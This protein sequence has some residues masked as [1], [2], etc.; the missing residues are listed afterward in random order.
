MMK[1]RLEFKREDM[2]IG[3]FWRRADGTRHIWICLL[4]CLPLHI[5]VKP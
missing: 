2:W 5:E 3:V 4:P 1:A